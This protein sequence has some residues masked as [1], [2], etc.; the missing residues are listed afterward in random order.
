VLSRDN[1]EDRSADMREAFDAASEKIA[2]PIVLPGRT[3]L[4]AA[5]LTVA[6]LPAAAPAALQS[7]AAASGGDVALA[8]SMVWSDE[9]F[10]WIATWR[11]GHRDRVSTWQVR[12]VNFDKAFRNGLR[13]VAQVL[14]GNG[15]PD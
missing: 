1:D 7:I 12:G 4:A 9:A 11:F 14:S 8:G 15:E 2:V 6:T 10:G 5:G 3:D 13:G